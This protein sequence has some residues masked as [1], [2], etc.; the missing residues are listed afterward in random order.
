MSITGCL[1]QL[2]DTALSYHNC[3]ASPV[4][5]ASLAQLR[6]I[7]HYKTLLSRCS[8]TEIKNRWMTSSPTAS[9]VPLLMTRHCCQS[10]GHCDACVHYQPEHPLSSRACE[11]LQMLCIDT[12]LAGASFDFGGCLDSSSHYNTAEFVSRCCLDANHSR[13]LNW[14]VADYLAEWQR[15]S[16][17]RDNLPFDSS[18]DSFVLAGALRR[19]CK[20][21]T[22][23]ADDIRDGTRISDASYYPNADFVGLGCRTNRSVQ[24]YAMDRRSVYGSAF[25]RRLFGN[26]VGATLLSDVSDEKSGKPSVAIVDINVSY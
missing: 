14:T 24:F 10:V 17:H 16:E 23:L 13:L 8:G 20:R 15:R 25:L 22:Q 6:L 11:R 7:S 3:N 5:G 18:A 21:S 12:V 1:F 9:E 26:R 2:R 19:F 4:F